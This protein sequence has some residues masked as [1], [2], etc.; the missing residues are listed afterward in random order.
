MSA[1][2]N[3][4]DKERGISEAD[5]ARLSFFVSEYRNSL[6]SPSAYGF[7]RKA[8]DI[9][10]GMIESGEVEKLGLKRDASDSLFRLCRNGFVTGSDHPSALDFPIH[11]SLTPAGLDFY[12]E[13]SEQK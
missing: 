11:F 2:E 12:K 5:F 9:H 7:S 10:D 4:I 13:H 8:S 6:L 1:Y 3:M